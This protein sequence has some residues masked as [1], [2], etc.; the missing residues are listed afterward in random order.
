LLA[1]RH[2]R[3]EAALLRHVA[4][5]EP[6]GRSDRELV[7][8]HR[9]GVGLSQTEDGAYCRRLPGSVGA[10][11]TEHAAPLDRERAVLERRHGSEL[12][13]DVDQTQHGRSCGRGAGRTTRTEQEA[14]CATRSET[15]PSVRAS[16]REDVV[17]FILG[18]LNP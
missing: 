4:E 17:A 14:S 5:A 1:D 16:A 15:L 6:L 12:L 3:I 9:S 11:E 13:A 10:E 18:F 7:P 2:A 8:E